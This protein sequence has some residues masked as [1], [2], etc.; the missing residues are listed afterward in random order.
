MRTIP[1]ATKNNMQICNFRIFQTTLWQINEKFARAVTT[2]LYT[3]QNLQ[4]T[5]TINDII[6]RST[7]NGLEWPWRHTPLS[8]S[9]I[10]ARHSRES[11][12]ARMFWRQFSRAKVEQLSPSHQCFTHEKLLSLHRWLIIGAVVA[13]AKQTA[14][15]GCVAPSA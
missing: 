6:I 10:H 14:S 1:T 2:L 13:S 15:L 12:N 5:L 3:W 9:M 8:Y 7:T 4:F 11:D